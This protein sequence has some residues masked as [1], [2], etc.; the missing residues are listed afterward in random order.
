MT[1]TRRVL[2]SAVSAVLFGWAVAGVARADTGIVPLVPRPHEHVQTAT[3]T[4]AAEL[5]SGTG[6]AV[7]RAD[8]R[9]LLDGH[10]VSDAITVADGRVRFVPATPLAVG[11]H[12]V[13]VNLVEPSGGRLSY[14]WTFTVDGAQQSE[15]DS[16]PS[17]APPAPSYV[18]QAAPAYS[19]G[20]LGSPMSYGTGFGSFYPLSPAPFYWGQAVRFVFV[21]VPGGHGFV[22]FGG[23]PGFF[24][25]IPLGVDTFFVVVPIPIGFLVPNPFI[26]CHFFPPFGQPIVVPFAHHLVILAHRRPA[27]LAL[28]HATTAMRAIKPPPLAVGAPPRARLVRTDPLPERR[29]LQ[30]VLREA[31][32]LFVTHVAAPI[33]GLRAPA[34]LLVSHP[35][36]RVH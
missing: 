27:T 20:M 35:A 33:T 25:L 10:D 2:V 1:Q 34:P 5:P 13:E 28:V 16:A 31:L 7:D 9:L 3:P 4:I 30:P 8:V 21:G 12:A 29:P 18:P 6:R 26:A 24:N 23:I 15:S 11:E 22:T 19:D 17:Y 32:P 36:S 14:Q